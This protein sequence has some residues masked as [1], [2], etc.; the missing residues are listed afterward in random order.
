M[1]TVETLLQALRAIVACVPACDASGGF[2]LEHRDQDG[3][4]LGIEQVNPADIIQAMDSLAHDALRAAQ[5]QEE[6]DDG[7]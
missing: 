3:E 7:A 1:T 6:A 5:C 4:F 2:F